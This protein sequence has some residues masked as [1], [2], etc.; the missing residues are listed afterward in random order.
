M[1]L[2]EYRAAAR[3]LEM[4]QEQLEETEQEVESL[5]QQKTALKGSVAL[6]K[7][8]DR[9]RVDL[10]TIQPEKTLTG[11]IRGVSVEQIG[12]LKQV[13]VQK[14][15]TDQQL[16]KV[17]EENQRLESLVPT[18]ED[19]MRENM[20]RQRMEQEIARLREERE[21]LL[22]QLEEERA[23]LD[24]VLDFLEGQLPEQFQPLVQEAVTLF[25]EENQIDEQERGNI[26]E[27][28]L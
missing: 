24:R 10:D 28:E 15:A 23:R 1:D 3:R 7:A 21:A 22:K 4:A 11:A 13:A 20:K 19:R 14:V 27:M 25:M 5:E 8:V 26:W 18:I 12:Q 9:V 6:L 17:L 16:R 2:P